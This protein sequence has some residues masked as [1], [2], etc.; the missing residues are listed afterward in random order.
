M[1]FERPSGSS[2]LDGQKWIEH[3]ITSSGSILDVANL[4]V[5]PD[6]ILILSHGGYYSTSNDTKIFRVSTRDG[7]L[8]WAQPL[9]KNPDRMTPFT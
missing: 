7:S 2:G 8:K 9:I 4:D 6:E 1:W 5:Y 3:Y